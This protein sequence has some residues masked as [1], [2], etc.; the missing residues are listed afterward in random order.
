M[1]HVAAGALRPFSPEGGGQDEGLGTPVFA[2][3]SEPLTPTLSPL[4]REFSVPASADFHDNL[5]IAAGPLRRIPARRRRPIK[6]A[7]GNAS[8]AVASNGNVGILAYSYKSRGM[9]CRAAR[10]G[11]P[12]LRGVA[13][14]MSCRA[15]HCSGCG[16]RSSARRRQ[17]AASPQQR[18]C[19]RHA[20][21]TGPPGRERVAIAALLQR[22]LDREAPRV[23]DRAELRL[24]FHAR[25]E[26]GGQHGEV[27]VVV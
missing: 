4:G 25:L 22:L 26:H 11:A 8:V 3:K 13:S 9:R 10:S 20:L 24:G 5:V 18:R 14:R 23:F 1:R 27:F 16:T 12:I 17:P 7:D 21:R 15:R 6:R 2:P 19:R